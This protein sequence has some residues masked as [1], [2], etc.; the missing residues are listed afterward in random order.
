MICG[1]DLA[2]HHCRNDVEVRLDSEFVV[3]QM[4]GDY[5][6]KSDN[7]KPLYDQVRALEGRF[8]GRVTY[9]HHPRSALLAKEADQLANEALQ[10]YL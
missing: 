1:L 7:I 6:I 2:A 10:P 3:R 4:N 5:G 8:R 9:H